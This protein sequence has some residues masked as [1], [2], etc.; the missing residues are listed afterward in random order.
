MVDYLETNKFYEIICSYLECSSSSKICCCLEKGIAFFYT[1]HCMLSVILNEWKRNK[2]NSKS[3][4]KTLS[5]R[6]SFF[7][8]NPFL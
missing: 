8:E 3:T 4:R 6:I 2:I 5:P 7:L 1:V